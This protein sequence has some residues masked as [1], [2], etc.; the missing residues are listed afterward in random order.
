MK[1]ETTSFEDRKAKD[2]IGEAF[3]EACREAELEGCPY[4]GKRFPVVANVDLDRLW[5]KLMAV[6]GVTV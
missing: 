5:E 6:I 2:L 1:Y 3:E 4:C